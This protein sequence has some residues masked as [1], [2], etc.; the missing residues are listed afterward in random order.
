MSLAG[1]DD[2]VLD[3]RNPLVGSTSDLAW[4]LWGG[5]PVLGV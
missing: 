4:R 1:G 5:Q 2:L 3:R